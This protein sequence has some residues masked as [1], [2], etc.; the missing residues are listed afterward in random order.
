MSTRGE[1]TLWAVWT[2]TG[3]PLRITTDTYRECRRRADHYRPGTS[4]TSPRPWS[5]P[6]LA[7]PGEPYAS[8]VGA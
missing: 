7:R 8:G 5:A 4:G 1:W 3:V 2:P 6:R